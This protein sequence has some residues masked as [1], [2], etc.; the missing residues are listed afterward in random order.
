MI[1]P[2]Q[3]LAH[4]FV[5]VSG[6]A[7]IVLA[8]CST[9]PPSLPTLSCPI[10][11]KQ[12]CRP[13]A[14]FGNGLYDT[15][16]TRDEKLVTHYEIDHLD[17]PLNSRDNEFGMAFLNMDEVNIGAVTSDRESDTG[18]Q[19]VWLF[20]AKSP[21]QFGD[22]SPLNGFSANGGSLAFNW[23]SM[24]V[25]FAARRAGGQPSDYD[26][27][28]ATF[29]KDGQGWKILNPIDLGDSINRI[30]SW[31]AQPAVSP[32]GKTL[33]FASDRPGGI[34]GTDIWCS[35]KQPNGQWGNAFNAGSAINTACDEITPFMSGDG[36]TLLFSSNGRTT[37][38]GY[39]IF[40]AKYKKGE[41]EDVVNIGPPVNTAADEI[42]PSSFVSPDSLLYYA[43]TQPGGLGGFDEFVIRKI[44]VPPPQALAIEK[45][46]EKP[47]KPPEF[48]AKIEPK[49]MLPDVV[50]KIDS[51]KMSGTVEDARSHAPISDAEVT[52]KLMPA[53]LNL[54]RVKTDRDGRYQLSLL[55]ETQYEVSAQAGKYFYDVFQLTT[56]KAIDTVVRIPHVFSLPETLFLR[57]NFPLNQSERPYE[58]TLNDSGQPATLSCTEALDLLADNL[59]TYKDKIKL[60]RLIGHTDSAGTDLYNERLGL[61]RAQFVKNQLIK[62]GVVESLITVESR[63]R[64]EPVVRRAGEPKET[65]DARCRR[66]ELSKVLV[67]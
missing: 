66:T 22:K 56:P 29:Q 40:R 15:V 57:V 50:E 30:Y 25:Y 45:P 54:G 49:K 58:F 18:R 55:P 11:P 67:N 65:F 19:S 1:P 37:L 8:G 41:P 20:P 27:Y 14:F 5:A 4:I 3:S 48:V 12:N 46:V 6:V 21:I 7:A 34:G 43:S 35:Q 63:G 31:D 38:G 9:L 2:R 64:T 10:P 59:R 26:I 17:A 13:E 39:D 42:F 52:W 60:L 33:Y 44:Y 62:R 53:R 24:T 28:S 36:H 23:S 51:V 32:D 61:R 47:I 16:A